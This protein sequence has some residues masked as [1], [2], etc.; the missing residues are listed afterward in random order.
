M[1]FKS[2]ITLKYDSEWTYGRS[3]Y[4]P[5]EHL[6]MEFPSD[7]LTTT[8]VFSAFRK[9]LLATGYQDSSIAVGAVSLAFSESLSEEQMRKTAEEYGLILSE[10]HYKEI[11][12]LE[13]KIDELEGKII[14][15]KAHLSR[16]QNPSDPN[17]TDEEMEAMEHYASK[18][19]P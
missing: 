11:R 1:S 8:Q 7:E 3:D 12:N 18:E 19:V 4:L 13:N 17:Y 9:F 2:S 5:E 15:L 10:D 6:V 16:A 14:S